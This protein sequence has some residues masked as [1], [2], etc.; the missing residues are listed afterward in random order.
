VTAIKVLGGIVERAISISDLDHVAVAQEQ[1]GAQQCATA[2]MVPTAE[3]VLVKWP[4]SKRVN[5]SRADETTQC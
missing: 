1:Y 2:L 5:S 3:D 4:V